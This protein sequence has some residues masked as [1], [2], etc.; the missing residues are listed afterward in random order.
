MFQDQK[1]Q[2]E[3]A[4]TESKGLANTFAAQNNPQLLKRQAL[5]NEEGELGMVQKR[6]DSNIAKQTEQGQYTAA[7][8]KQLAA[9]DEGKLKQ[10]EH[11]ARIMMYSEDPAIS[12]KGKAMMMKH[13]ELV[14]MAEQ[15]RLN[16]EQKKMERDSAERIARMNRD[17]AEKVATISANARIAA[18][19]AGNSVKDV[20]T[21]VQSGKVSPDKAAAAFG[22]A[23]LQA[24][25][26][27][28]EENFTIYSNAA[29]VMERLANTVKPDAQ[30]GK[31]DMNNMGIP[32]NPPRAPVFPPADPRGPLSQKLFP[33]QP[34]KDPRGPTAS[35]PVLPEGAKQ[36]GTSKG[37]PVYEIN[38][39]RFIVGE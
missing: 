1:L 33:L 19:T 26:S 35:G 6:I 22:A 15:A 24:Q 38:G 21:S 18:K 14:K 7:Q 20:F 27:G 25:A 23:A 11:Q 5:A 3:R 10:I 9:L 34:D 28:D 39:K 8:M 2:Q 36:V 17:S 16:M 13:P 4:L 31:P 12:A 32:T 37:K 30:A 29:S